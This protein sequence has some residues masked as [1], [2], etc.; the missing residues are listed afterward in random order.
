VSCDVDAASLFLNYTWLRQG[1]AVKVGFCIR[2][3]DPG[4]PV[5][6]SPGIMAVKAPPSK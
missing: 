1:D 6:P 2:F 5:A 3:G 4:V